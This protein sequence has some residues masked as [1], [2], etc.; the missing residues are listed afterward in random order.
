MAGFAPVGSTPVASLG[1]GSAPVGTYITPAGPATIIIAG[2][3]GYVNPGVRISKTNFAIE[4]R[5]ISGAVISKTNF[6]VESHP[7]PGSYISK[8]NFAIESNLIVSSSKGSI[9][10]LW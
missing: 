7:T 2:S 5:P 4:S 6:A 10:I 3:S 9:S 1:G 8:T